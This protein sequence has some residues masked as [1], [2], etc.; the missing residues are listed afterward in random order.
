MS[1]AVGR[2]DGMSKC[3]RDHFLLYI[4][5]WREKEL[6]PSDLLLE[7]KQLRKE[8][9]VRIAW[10][11]ENARSRLQCNSKEIIRRFISWSSGDTES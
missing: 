6:V 1:F 8:N 7:T 2:V 11:V 4:K 9:M 3:I 10:P 5:I